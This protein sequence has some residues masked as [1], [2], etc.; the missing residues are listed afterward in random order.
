L[1]GVNEINA[2][3]LLEFAGV[4][5]IFFIKILV[6]EYIMSL[7]EQTGEYSSKAVMTCVSYEAPTVY[8]Y[9]FGAVDAEIMLVS[10]E[11]EQLYTSNV[12]DVV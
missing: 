2:T 10:G 12:N 8:D 1:L 11:F 6:I 3:D 4:A 7:C 5:S 9:E